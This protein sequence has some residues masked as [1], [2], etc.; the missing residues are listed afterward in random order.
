LEALISGTHPLAVLILVDD[1]AGTVVGG[2]SQGDRLARN[3]REAW[4]GAE[5]T[6]LERDGKVEGDARA[7]LASPSVVLLRTNLVVGRGVLPRLAA[8]AG[9]GRTVPVRL[10]AGAE[11]APSGVLEWDYLAGLLPA[12]SDG[13]ADGLGF[14][15]VMDQT[16]SPR[17]A[18]RRLLS[19][20]GKPSDG[21]VARHINRP[22]S[23]R[24]TR[25]LAPTRVTPD[26]VSL[27]VL[28]LALGAAGF[29]AQG[30]GAG[31]VLG[32]LLNQAASMLDGTDGELARLKFMETRRGAWMDTTIDLFGNHLFILALGVGLS[33]QADLSPAMRS[34]YLLE[35]VLTLLGSA[36]CVWLVARQTNR[37]TGEAHFNNFNAPLA[38]AVGRGGLLQRA[39][40]A[41]LPLFRRDSYALLFLV[42]AVLGHPAWVLHLL[43]IGVLAHF[44]AIGWVLWNHQSVASLAGPDRKALNG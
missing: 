3:V 16:V 18:E 43:A 11:L 12:E 40:A 22:F 7:L 4:P 15:V 17:E 44:P 26:V 6:L 28:G 25:V 34:N 2:L 20:L 35:G 39:F 5:L 27:V 13:A 30:T 31:F 9:N 42:L 36:L 21:Y 19:S 14:F 8:A 33:R 29:T 10:L 1:T 24:L 32:C 37:T 23:T 38:K 41:A